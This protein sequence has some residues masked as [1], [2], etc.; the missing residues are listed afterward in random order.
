MLII[1]TKQWKKALGGPLTIGDGLRCLSLV[2]SFKNRSVNVF[3]TEPITLI[4]IS[5]ISYFLTTKEKP[6]T[7]R[8]GLVLSVQTVCP[9]L[10]GTQEDV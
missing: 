9:E 3:R 6:K 4:K 1:D 8:L 2:G 7:E 5:P 10:I